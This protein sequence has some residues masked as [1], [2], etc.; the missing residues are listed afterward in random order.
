M[1]FLEATHT[2]LYPGHR[3]EIRDLDRIAGLSRE[4]DCLVEFSDGQVTVARLSIQNGDWQ[5]DANAYK[6]A[7]G[8]AIAGKRWRISMEESDGPVRFRV[9]ERIC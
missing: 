8:T 9:L 5:L 1:I 3:G 2:H 7:A 6:T 4:M